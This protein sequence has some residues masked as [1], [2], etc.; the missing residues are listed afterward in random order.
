M[1]QDCI[2]QPQLFQDAADK[3]TSL[4]TDRDLAKVDL[5]TEYAQLDQKY[6][7]GAMDRGEKITDKTVDSLINGTAS[8]IEQK[9]NYIIMKTLAYHADNEKTAYEQR[10]SMLEYIIRLF[11]S[12][13]YSDV[14]TSHEKA[15]GP[16]RA[17]MANK[18]KKE[19]YN[20]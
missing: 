9:K 12:D 7:K 3:A 8:Y 10:K 17:I 14:D 2:E 20:K 19:L 13:Y 4:A 16:T 15:S 5:E 11:L 18:I 6:R 1:D